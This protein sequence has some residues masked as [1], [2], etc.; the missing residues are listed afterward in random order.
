MATIFSNTIDAD[1]ALINPQ[2][3]VN[4]ITLAA[5]STIPSTT[6]VIRT[7]NAGAI[8]GVI[9]QPGVISGQQLVI[10]NEAV[11]ANTITMAAAGTSNVAGGVTV[12][13]SGLAAHIFIW[14]GGT[15]LWYQVGPAAN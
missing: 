8:A 4:T 7:T 11:A 13:L 6:G 5:S 1:N 9:I 12:V 3:G 14:N 15:S 10:Y 2:A